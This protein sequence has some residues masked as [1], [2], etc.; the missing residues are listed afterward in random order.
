MDNAMKLAA[1]AL[2]LA[3]S[4]AGAGTLADKATAADAKHEAFVEG[5]NGYRF[6]PAELRFA[7]KL[8]SPEISS[9]TAPGIGVI[10]DFSAQLKE[11]GV[12]LVVVPV[13]PKA[14]VQS[15]S[16]GIGA[17]EQLAMRVGWENIMNELSAQ[18]IQVVDLLGDYLS[19]KETI[20][21]L[22]D[23]HWSGHGI[24]VAV[25]RLLPA[26]QAAGLPVNKDSGAVPWK[27]AMINGDL[28]GEP[29]KVK[30]R[31]PAA[32][33]STASAPLLLLGDSHV[34]VFHQGGDLHAAG[35]GLPEQLAAVIG[36]MPHVMGVR[37]SGA[38]SSRLQLARHVRSTPDYLGS[39]KMIVWVFAGREF[40]EADMWKKIPVVPKT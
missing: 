12:A 1:T 8:A 30:L 10:T 35:A 17:D 37:G 32:S 14:L 11:K 25:Q 31:F 4:C 20:F 16:L 24:D 21:C 22:R 18:G 6:L 2:L 38:T 19:A 34:L 23:T 29:E 7:D 3:A 40:T 28:G 27:E 39:K 33:S 36:G 9:L 15:A 26:M 5:A 13:P